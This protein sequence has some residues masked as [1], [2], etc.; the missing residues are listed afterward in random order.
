M[1]DEAA[2]RRA[3][4]G[5]RGAQVELGLAI[6]ARNEAGEIGACIAA[7]AS[8]LGGAGR[9]AATVLVNGSTDGTADC[10]RRA[11]ANAPRLQVDVVEAPLPRGTPS[12]GAA[13]SRALELARAGLADGGILA[14]TD[15]D[16]RPA[17][18]WGAAMRAALR[19]ADVVFGPVEL[20]WPAGTDRLARIA[21]LEE[22]A[23]DLQAALLTPPGAPAPAHSWLSGASFGMTAAAWDL[24]GGLSP[25]PGE[26]R[27]LAEAAWRAGLR[28]V[29]ADLPP[30]RTS[31]R[32]S[33]RAAGGMAE[34]LA[35]RMAD[36]DPTCDARLLPL[37]ALWTA[38]ELRA[39]IA[40]HRA[41]ACGLDP[42]LCLPGAGAAQ[43]LTALRRADPRF[44]PAPMRLSALEAALPELR[45][46]AGRGAQCSTAAS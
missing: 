26:D 21:A 44:A 18:G 11:A 30:V 9:A 16:S 1:Y 29:Q 34:T 22:E 32:L 33:G 4:A 5:A 25:G 45:R 31:G 23:L 14:S 37:D 20:R 41:Q 10:A 17:A 46:L 12:A 42:E 8:A 35:R 7:V 3:E 39:R 15:A 28:V 36:P 38:R 27:A 19:S 24:L 6:P 2:P 40:M 13:R 43:F